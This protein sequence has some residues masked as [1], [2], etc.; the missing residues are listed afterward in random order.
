[1]VVVTSLFNLVISSFHDNMFYLVLSCM[2]NAVDL[3]SMVPTTLFKSV[4]SSSHEQSVS[5]Y[6]NKPVNT[7]QGGQLNYVQACQQHSSS[8]PAQLCSS[9]QH[10]NTQNTQNK[11]CR[12]L[13]V[14][15]WGIK[16]LTTQTHLERYLFDHLF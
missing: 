5:T 13:L 2:N 10:A 14:S 1:M 12:F 15:K 9:L 7:V 4:R 16:L 11:L 6:T 8:W 3:S